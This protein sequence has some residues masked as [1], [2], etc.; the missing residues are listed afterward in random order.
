MVPEEKKGDYIM[1]TLEIIKRCLRGKRDYFGVTL[2]AESTKPAPC[3]CKDPSPEDPCIPIYEYTIY[4]DLPESTDSKRIKKLLPISIEKSDT[5]GGLR[6]LLIRILSTN[7]NME[8]VEN[9]E[10]ASTV[11]HLALENYISMY[12]NRVIRAFTEGEI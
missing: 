5:P 4:I 10:E 9:G 2:Y 11:I 1:D 3:G 7:N 6:V 12:L 8:I